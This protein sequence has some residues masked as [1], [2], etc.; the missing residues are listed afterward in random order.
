MADAKNQ[1][2]DQI[3]EMVSDTLVGKQIDKDKLKT[4]TEEIE[5][6]TGR[7]LTRTCNFSLTISK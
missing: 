7:P 2:I 5:R 3:F 4:V 6:V 1:L